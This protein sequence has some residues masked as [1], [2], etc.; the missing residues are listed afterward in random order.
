[1]YGR[2]FLAFEKRSPSRTLGMFCVMSV[3]IKLI[4]T[5]QNSHIYQPPF[6]TIYVHYDSIEEVCDLKSNYRFRADITKEEF[7]KHPNDDS[8]GKIG[9]QYFQF[10]PTSLVLVRPHYVPGQNPDGLY[11]KMNSHAS[12]IVDKIEQSIIDFEVKKSLA[13]EEALNPP[14]EK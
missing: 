7:E 1:M 5:E 10:F 3:F 4:G 2:V 6:K 14:K 12:E 13:V 11:L 8:Y 9:E